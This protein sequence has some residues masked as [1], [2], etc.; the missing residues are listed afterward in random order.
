METNG[1]RQRS[2]ESNNYGS[3][4]GKIVITEAGKA[5]DKR[6]DQHETYGRV[7]LL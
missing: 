1:L 2:V 5:V 3:T 4:N 7:F 6:L